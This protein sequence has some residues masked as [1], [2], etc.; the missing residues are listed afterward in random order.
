MNPRRGDI[1]VLFH[2]GTEETYHP[3]S[4]R[5]FEGVLHLYPGRNRMDMPDTHIPLAGIRKWET[6]Q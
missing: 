6:V 3:D 4:T 1:R 5:I 2:D